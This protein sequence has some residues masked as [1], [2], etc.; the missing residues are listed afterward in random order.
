VAFI[1]SQTMSESVELWLF[2]GPPRNLRPTVELLGQGLTP[3]D[4]RVVLSGSVLAD[5]A[6]YGEQLVLSIPPV[7]TLPLEPDASILTLS[8]TVGTA[9]RRG[10]H[11][12]NTVRAPEK[13]PAGGFPLAGEFTYADGSR[14][15]TRA[16]MPCP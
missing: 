14:G 8:L 10:V 11:R 6:P 4:K 5:G 1:G 7:R 12:A 16:A 2:L 9:S 3:F 13:C 15:S